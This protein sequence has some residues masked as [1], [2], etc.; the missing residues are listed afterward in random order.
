MSEK[1]PSNLWT[2]IMGF[3]VIG[4]VLTCSGGLLDGCIVWSR[5]DVSTTELAFGHRFLQRASGWEQIADENPV[6]LLDGFI[7]CFYYLETQGEDAAVYSTNCATEPEVL[8][9]VAGLSPKD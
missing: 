8:E 7:P 3:V 6:L 2:G 1:S 5:T 9:K 4:M